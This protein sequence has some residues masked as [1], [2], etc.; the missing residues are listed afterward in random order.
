MERIGSI[1]SSLAVVS[2]ST[3]S[4]TSLQNYVTNERLD[5]LAADLGKMAILRGGVMDAM[6]L[7]VYS[8]ALAEE[9]PDETDT[10]VV[11][12]RLVRSRRG[13]FE[14]KIPELGD[15]MELIREERGRRMK[16]A[17]EQREADEYEA[18]RRD[19]ELH[20]EKYCSVQEFWSE[21]TAKLGKKST[22]EVRA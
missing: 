22:A 9:F 2:G 6:L 1:S 5:R 10:M 15:F 4:S 13:E 3:S 21:V 12:N 14:A 19:R 18:L 11:M 20:P 8:Q 17:R 7:G 16:A